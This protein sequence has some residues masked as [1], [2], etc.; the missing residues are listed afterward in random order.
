MARQLQLAGEETALLLL[1][2]SA[3]PNGPYDRLEWWRPAFLARFLRNTA[4]WIQDFLRLKPAERSELIK[5]K[6]GVLKRSLAQRVSP[7]GRGVIDV[8][9]F[10]DTSQFP[11][12]ELKLWQIH[13]RAGGDYKPKP[14][15]GRVTLLR[16][17]RQP[18]LCSF[19]PLYGWGDLAQEGVEIHLIPGSHE[20][21]FVEPDVLALAAQVNARLET[22]QHSH[23][24]SQPLT[25]NV[26]SD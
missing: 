13:L 1:I 11:D 8:E 5:R 17:R 21:I 18:F 9:E 20:A 2:D 14:Y 3:A 12:D 19:D 24:K 23:P 25:E 4:Y 15:A 10:I 26:K 16:T 22:V 7:S 6:M